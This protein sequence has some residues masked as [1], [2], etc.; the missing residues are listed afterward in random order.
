MKVRLRNEFGIPIN[1]L[2]ANQITLYFQR[3]DGGMLG[4]KDFS[5]VDAQNGVLEFTLTD[6]EVQ[7]LKTGKHQDFFA[8]VVVG[9]EVLTIEFS[10]GLDVVIKDE[11]KHLCEQ[12]SP[13][14]I[15]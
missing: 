10:K 2:K 5:V 8:K 1:L 14:Q 3:D 12:T 15:I 6:F 9:D 4:K 13:I 11:R 7:A